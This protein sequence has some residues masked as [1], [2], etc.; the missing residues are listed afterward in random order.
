MTH[1]VNGS[2]ILAGSGQRVTEICAAVNYVLVVW[3]S[4]QRHHYSYKTDWVTDGS[5]QVTGQKFRPGCFHH[6][7]ASCRQSTLCILLLVIV[8]SICNTELLFATGKKTNKLI[9]LITKNTTSLICHNKI[10][11]SQQ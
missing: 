1:E 5:G 8:H 4:R 11:R 3:N 10:L 2:T 6:C 7:L 9:T